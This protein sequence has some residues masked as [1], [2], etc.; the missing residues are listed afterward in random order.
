MKMTLKDLAHTALCSAIL[1][2]IA[3]FSL[4]AGANLVPISLATF[5]VML[6]GLLFGW[7]K[8]VTATAVYLA[9][10]A[11]GLPVFAKGAGGIAVLA[12]PTGG[13]LIGYLFLAF[14]SGVF[15]H[16]KF[17]MQLLMVLAGTV[18]LYAFGTAW[19]M[20]QQKAALVPS[21]LSCVVPFLPGDAAKIAG[22]FA[23]QHVFRKR[24]LT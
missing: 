15:V 3:P 4:T 19:F 22:A 1:C 24:K 9:L 20:I 21:L 13:Y 2:V 18:I 23:L 7:A 11:V 14:F 8:A 12:G 16:R 10:G 6:F 17:W 5:C